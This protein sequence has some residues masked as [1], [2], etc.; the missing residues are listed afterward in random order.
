VGRG[1]LRKQQVDLSAIASSIVSGLRERDSARQVDVRIADC[2]VVEGDPGLLR[3]ML[4]NV[5]GNAWK[6]TARC[7]Q[8]AIEI[9]ACERDGQRAFFVRDNGVGFEPEK[10][11]RLF[12][13]FQ[14][15]HTHA[16]FEGTGVGLATVHRIV[17]RHGGRVWAEGSKGNGATIYFTLARD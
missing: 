2:L 9:G 3:A 12:Q 7:E 6:F 13:P 10:A 4:E 15:L 11:G 17:T 14:R 16:E 1:E 8:A 5:V